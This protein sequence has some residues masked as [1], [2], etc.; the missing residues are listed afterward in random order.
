MR[1][2]RG[3]AQDRDQPLRSGVCARRLR[4]GDVVHGLPASEPPGQV[5]PESADLAA[6]LD[7]H[8]LG[9]AL[10]GTDKN[11]A[12]DAAERTDARS[13]EDRCHARQLLGPVA[14]LGGTCQVVER[15]HGVRLA[16]AEIGLEPD[17][18]VA[19]LAG[20]PR[21]GCRQD[22]R[23]PLGRIGDPEERRRIDVFLAPLALI[24]QRKVRGELGVGEAGTEHIRM[25]LADF[26]PRAEASGCGRL[27]QG[28]CLGRRGMLATLLRQLLVV[29]CSDEPDLRSGTNRERQLAHGIEVADRLA[30]RH[31]AGEV[32]GAI[33]R[34]H[35]DRD[36]ASRLPQPS[37]VREE[38]P[39]VVKQGLQECVDVRFS[40]PV[41]A[42]RTARVLAPPAAVALAHHPL[43]V[44]TERDP[45]RIETS[46]HLYLGCKRRIVIAA[47]RTVSV[48]QDLIHPT[49]D[50]QHRG[51]LGSPPADA[52]RILRSIG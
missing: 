43:D 42:P 52:A 29:E 23:E 38:V 18:R 2:G 17:H 4:I 30:G 15:Q 34:I 11:R 44:G 40:G 22:A 19:A 3:A 7:V 49:Q 9:R 6:V 10:V 5:A 21:E 31:P 20:Q 48:A 37:I 47:H 27:V 39:P 28:Q 14:C 41:A 36:V 24:D 1:H 16:A 13:L 33:T 12:A 8:R 25:R 50:V 51:R 32:R 45:E 46:L 35:G 26:A